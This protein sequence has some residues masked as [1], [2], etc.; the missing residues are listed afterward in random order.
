MNS[1]H[2]VIVGAG[3]AGLACAT[4]L[5]QAGR[6]VL[7]LERNHR[8]GPKVCAGGVTWSG[9]QQR[10]PESLLQRSFPDQ[11]LSTRLQQTVI[12]AAQPLISTVDREELGQ[13]QLQEA[14]AAGVNI[15]TGALVGRIGKN[16]LEVHGKE[17]TFAHLVGADGSSS[18][19][20]KHL[21][22]ATQEVGVGLNFFIE[23]DFPRME[24]HL[25]DHF[26]NN[27]YAWIFPHRERASIGAYAARRFTR[28]T[29]LRKNFLLWA[30]KHGINPGAAKLSAGLINYDYRGWR[31]GNHFLVGDAAGLASALTGE[32]I[33][34]AIVSG[35]EVARTIL[36]PGYQAPRM[37]RLLA[38]HRRHLQVVRLTGASRLACRLTMESLV[39]G[40]RVGLIDFSTLEMAG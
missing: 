21:G 19:V 11:H 22:L 4:L 31:F 6:E 27:G 38:R 26:F 2:T 37:A 3:P 32:G 36:D 40:L 7:L 25:D 35:E 16:A 30:A 28:P 33:Y 10:L 12:S 24:W 23:G 13:W 17:V 5:A 9:M 14:S 20:R 18:L 39:L 15:I 8:V 34:P 1:Y 29:E